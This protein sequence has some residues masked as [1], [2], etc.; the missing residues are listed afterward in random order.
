MGDCGISP[1]R[2]IIFAFNKVQHINI[3]NKFKALYNSTRYISIFHR[4]SIV[5]KLIPLERHFN[6]FCMSICEIY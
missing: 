4:H 2:L 1:F 5:V 6:L 3:S